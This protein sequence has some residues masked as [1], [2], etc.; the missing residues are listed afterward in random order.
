MPP[1]GAH[2]LVAQPGHYCTLNRMLS[3]NACPAKIIYGII[4]LQDENIH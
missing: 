4:T 2:M 1:K 3:M